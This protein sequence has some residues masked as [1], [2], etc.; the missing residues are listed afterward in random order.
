MTSNNRYQQW[1]GRVENQVLILTT[2]H[3]KTMTSLSP[4]RRNEEGYRS[5]KTSLE[6]IRHDLRRSRVTSIDEQD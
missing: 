4:E 3:K 2:R 6:E 5:Y 1:T